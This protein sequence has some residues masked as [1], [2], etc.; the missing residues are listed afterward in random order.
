M[1][2]PQLVVLSHYLQEKHIGKVYG[3][4]QLS[5]HKIMA[6]MLQGSVLGAAAL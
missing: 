1:G 2:G 4:R 5:P 3:G 6:G